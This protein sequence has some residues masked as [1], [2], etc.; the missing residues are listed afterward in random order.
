MKP[1]VSPSAFRGA[2]LAVLLA[3]PCWAGLYAA[4][5]WLLT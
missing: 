1:A 5:R 2:L 3:L 4:L